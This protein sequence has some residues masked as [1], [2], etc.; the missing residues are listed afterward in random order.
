MLVPTSRRVVSCLLS[1]GILMFLAPAA[2][3]QQAPATPSQLAGPAALAKLLPAPEGWT[4]SDVRSNQI[5]ISSDC[6]YTFASVTYTKG[7]VRLK[8]TLSDTGSHAESLAALASMVVSL[9]DGHVGQIPPATTIHRM[10]IGESPAATM[11]DAANM[12]GE[13][14]VLVGGR[15]V[16]SVET[17]KADSLEMLQ[18]VLA[19]VDLKALGALK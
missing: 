10:K 8:L 16:A 19:G 9:P 4:R 15:F 7:D 18:T 14:V 6:S 13:I 5:D 11:W 3:M 2:A 1:T 17:Q 12:T